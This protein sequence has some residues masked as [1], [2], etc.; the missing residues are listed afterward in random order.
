M[1]SYLSKW[2][3]VIAASS[4]QLAQAT[5][6]YVNPKNLSPSA[7]YTTWQTASQTIQPAIDVASSGDE[8]VLKASTYRLSSTLLLQEGV[9]VVADFGALVTIDGQGLVRC[10]DFSPA[11]KISTPPVLKDLKIINGH[12]GTGNNGGAVFCNTKGSVTLENCTLQNNRAAAGGATYGDVH[13]T[14][15]SF[16]DNIAF[17]SDGGAMYAGSASDCLFTG[18]RSTLGGALRNATAYN[19]TVSQNLANSDGGGFYNVNS[20]N[21]IVWG[22]SA[23]RYGDDIY[24]G[25][26]S[27]TCAS[28]G[29]TNGI[30]GCIT[31][32][33]QFIDSYNGDFHL[34]RT[35]PC[36][37]AGDNSKVQ[38][39]EDLDGNDRIYKESS[40]GIVDL[41]AYET[42]TIRPVT[43]YVNVNILNGEYPYTSSNSPASSLANIEDLWEGDDSVIVYPGIYSIY[44]PITVSKP[45]TITGIPDGSNLP[46]LYGSTY[47]HPQ[48]TGLILTTNCVIDGLKLYNFNNTAII[49][50]NN[51]PVVKNCKIWSNSGHYGGGASNGTFVGCSFKYNTATLGGGMYDGTAT[52][53]TFSGNIARA[54]GGGAY[55]SDVSTSIF[56]SNTATNSGGAVHYGSAGNCLIYKN[57]SHDHGG[58]VTY[59]SLHN[60]T[61]VYNHAD[62]TAGGVY[63]GSLYNS[64]VWNNT[65]SSYSEIKS[66]TATY[67]CCIK[68]Y[69]SGTGSITNNPL[70]I[71]AA[72]DD[73][74]LRIDSPCVDSGSSVYATGNEDLDGNPRITGSQPD[75]GAYE[76][77]AQAGADT[78]EDGL[79]DTWEQ[80]Q[81]GGNAQP[82]EDADTD[83]FDNYS[84]YV[85][86]T[87]PND[88]TAFLHI[89]SNSVSGVSAGTEILLEWTPS[90][91]SRIYGISWSTN[92]VDGF[93]SLDVQLP[94]PSDSYTITNDLPNAFYKINV[95]LE[96]E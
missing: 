15:C 88:D 24:I 61:V 84:E 18:N 81:F 95:Q 19:C 41:G 28:S 96:N 3:A 53:C 37:D 75:M 10:F 31:N 69:P 44:E 6:H 63:E 49:C 66:G 16:F 27:N 59:T 33:P 32:S 91:A 85:A 2:I 9:T 21:C 50:S 39:T 65:A 46:S 93:Q 7:P 5:T 26:A 8:V 22:N 11:G 25:S 83:A 82:T 1:K 94:H 4:C 17:S 58:G 70:F 14:H 76:F 56:Y 57:T 77:L 35:S 78:D 90:V 79:P 40:G 73:Y 12:A 55:G 64:I 13:A 23:S 51:T 71:D 62:N 60:S 87:D 72:N 48:I 80:D 52:N 89:V 36:L 92:L 20:F 86:G 47:S 38:T 29:V 34:F 43:F 68:G 74:R 42:S 54:S 45:I 30:N 67:Y